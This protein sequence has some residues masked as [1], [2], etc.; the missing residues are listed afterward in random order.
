[1][2]KIHRKHEK[3]KTKHNNENRVN[4][5][6]KLEQLNETFIHSFDIS[7]ISKWEKHG[8][9]S[10]GTTNENYKRFI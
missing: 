2:A 6:N 3:I 9:K 1:M 7:F 4:M 5:N 8:N 10:Q